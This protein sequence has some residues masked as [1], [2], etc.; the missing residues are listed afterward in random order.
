MKKYVKPD[1]LYENF[2][3]SQSVAACSLDMSNSVDVNSCTATPDSSMSG[4]DGLTLFANGNDACTYTGLED[5]CLT[6]GSDG[7]SVFNS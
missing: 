3:L 7:F 2:E 5:Y 4:M 1:F 6:N